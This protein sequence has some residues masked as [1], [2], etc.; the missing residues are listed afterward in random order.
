MNKDQLLLEKAYNRIY[1]KEGVLTDQVKTKINDFAKQYGKQI[2]DFIQKKFP[3]FYE[4]L[5][6]TQGDATAIQNLIR[7]YFQNQKAPVQEEGVLGNIGDITKRF[8]SKL[9]NYQTLGAL[10]TA[11]GT[12]SLGL[13]DFMVKGPGM[14]KDLA[15][16]GV[17]S[18]L[19]GIYG[20]WI[21][22]QENSPK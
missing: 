4:E 15:I 14:E 6:A 13:A 5:A 22:S 11:L 20:F 16:M 10:L 9:F 3:D 12:V 7:P 8:I 18:L 19:V 2:K 21:N 1:L 17:V